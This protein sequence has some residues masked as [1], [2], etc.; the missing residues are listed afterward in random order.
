MAVTSEVRSELGIHGTLYDHQPTQL[1]LQGVIEVTGKRDPWHLKKSRRIQVDLNDTQKIAALRNSFQKIPSYGW[2]L[3]VHRHVEYLHR[4][5]GQKAQRLAHKPMHIWKEHLQDDT[6]DAV[7]AKSLARKNFFAKKNTNRVAQLRVFWNLWSG[8]M[9][10]EDDHPLKDSYFELAMATLHFR[11]LSIA[12]QKL[13]RRDD[14]SFLKSFVERAEEAANQNDTKKLWQQLKRFLPRHREKRRGTNARQNEALKDQWAPHL[15]QMEAGRVFDAESLYR[16]CCARQ[17][18]RTGLCPERKEIPTLLAVEWTLR[19]S[20]AGRQGGMDKVEPSWV[21]CAAREIAPHLWKISLKQSLWGVEAIQFKGGALT[22]LRKPGGNHS[23]VSG[24][25]GILLSAELGKRLQALV[26]KEMVA[27]I[28]PVR[29]PLQLGGFQNMEPAF[30]A[31]FVRAYTKVCSLKKCSST[32]IF[33]DLKAAYHSLIRELLTGRCDGDNRDVDTIFSCL[34]KEGIDPQKIQEHLDSTCILDELNVSESLKQRMQ[35]YNKD[36]WANL[37]GSG[38][39]VRTC[40]GSRPGSPLADIQFS[41]LMTKIGHFLQQRLEDYPEIRQ[42][43]EVVGLAP[44]AV[45]WADDLA[46]VF[47]TLD[48]TRTLEITASMMHATQS[49]FAERGLTVN[50]KKGKSEAIVSLCGKG[51]REQRQRMLEQPTIQI[52]QDEGPSLRLEGRYRH[53]GTYQQC[54]G[55][56]DQ[57]ITFRIASTWTS[58]RQVRHLLSRQTMDLQVRLRLMQSLLMSRLLY[59]AGAWYRLSKQQLKK[60]HICYLGLIRYIVGRVQ[61]KHQTHHGWTDEKILAEFD[62]PCIRTLLAVARLTYARRVWLHGGPLMQEV[63]IKEEQTYSSSWMSGL[64]E[65]LEWLY[66]VQGNKWGLEFEK[67][68]S[69]WL[70]GVKG[71]KAFVRGAQ[72]KH[73]LQEA[74][75]YSLRQRFGWVRVVGDDTF[76]P[77]EGWLCSCGA[78]FAQWKSLQIHRHKKHGLH[79]D[80]Y[81]RVSG[82]ICP[83]CLRQFWS[84]QRL[85]L[86]LKYQPRDGTGNKCW[87][88]IDTLQLQREEHQPE[89]APIPLIGIQRRDAIQCSGPLWFGMSNDDANY[90]NQRIAFLEEQMAVQGLDDP[91]ELLNDGLGDELL[92]I[93]VNG[94]DDWKSDLSELRAQYQHGLLFTVN[95]LFSGARFQWQDRNEQGAW[96]DYVESCALGKELCEWFDLKLRV[97]FLTRAA[98]TSLNFRPHESNKCAAGKKEAEQNWTRSIVALPLDEIR[99]PG[100]DLIAVKAPG[101]S[102]KFLLFASKR[103]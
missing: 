96:R 58:F 37:F 14:N 82:T 33:V 32:T 6:W 2:D 45:I 83:A 64:K 47:P 20:K 49:H 90:A 92:F 1:H 102:V 17:D 7:R 74:I 73:T 36:T 15:C 13:V 53:L 28:A 26:R 4:T 65:D 77:D 93:F 38:C 81:N 75:A 79:S 103:C 54:G 85:H 24:F 61:T 69:L 11:H 80:I 84:H 40:R 86:H 18:A 60:M 55:G 76:E 5:I 62:L 22:M 56:L 25:R 72:R 87:S 41:S 98:E 16:N 50:F 94:G 23:E 70:Q 43:S 9:K 48:S 71:W 57:E 91:G 31:H 8:K 12:A 99:L 59:G 101:V 42:A 88:F 68:S 67:T 51:S 3:D 44:A 100:L 10:E 63:L 21:K 35:E 95:L 34:E 46:L 89:D 78:W 66:A 29:P 27:Q 52:G 97:A 19:E 30:G 39:L